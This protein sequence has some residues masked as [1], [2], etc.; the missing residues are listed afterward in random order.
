MIDTKKEVERYVMATVATPQSVDP[1][2]SLDELERLLETAGAVSVGRLVQN[3]DHADQSTYL[4]SGKV[5]ELAT[6]AT[7]CEATGIVCDDELSPAQLKNLEKAFSTLGVSFKII[8]RTLLILDIFAAHANTNEGKIQV[9]KA[10]L[11]YRASRLTGLG[12]SLS[13]LGGGIGTRGPGETKLET[14]RRLIRKRISILSGQ[15][16]EMQQNRD[17]G[18]K[19]RIKTGIPVIAIVGYTNA[20][21]S[22]LLNYMTDGSILAE[23]K[24]F[25]TLDPTTRNCKLQSGQEV[26]FT[27]TV[28]FIHKL[29]HHL[30]DAFRSTLEEAKYADIILHVLDASDPDME[31]HRAVVYET[32]ESL[33]VIGKPVVTAFNKMD[34][35]EGVIDTKDQTADA[36]LCISGKTGEGV[37]ELLAK[38]EEILR[39]SQ[40]YLDEVIPYEQG[41]RLAKI[42]Q[43]GQLLLEEYTEEGIHIQAYVPRQLA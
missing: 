24:L 13:R 40:V 33:G 25:A 29:P 6:F 16:K 42:R 14:D 10:Q 4:G 38:I 18:R 17:V 37:A 32:L 27:D 22:T 23:D 43:Q 35:V 41:G 7:A 2:V 5:E 12:T 34:L 36:T 11:E 8:D 1:E 19:M 20:G 9:E 3:L 15:I 31:L 28:G 39:A 21:K 26:L 30:V